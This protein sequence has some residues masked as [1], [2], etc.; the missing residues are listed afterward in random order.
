MLTLLYAMNLFGHI[1][2]LW[3]QYAVASFPGYM[4]SLISRLHGEPHS[5][6]TCEPHSQATW[7]ASFPGYMG[8]L[9][10]R[11]HGKPHS[12]AT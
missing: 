6:A 9:I 5:Q 1:I 2:C 3:T 8:S 10:P 4:V 11:P 12:Q 7:G